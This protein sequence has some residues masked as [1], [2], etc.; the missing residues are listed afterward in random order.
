MTCQDGEYECWAFYRY[1][2][3]QGKWS[4]QHNFFPRSI[5]D[6]IGGAKETVAENK[7]VNDYNLCLLKDWFSDICL[8]IQVVEENNKKHCDWGDYI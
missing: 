3:L 7:I 2:T 5:N 4:K 1:K 8:W 6:I